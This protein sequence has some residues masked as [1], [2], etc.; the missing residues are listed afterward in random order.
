MTVRLQWVHFSILGVSI[1]GLPVG[2]A[3]VI[4]E[5]GR[6]T[7]DGLSFFFSTIA[8]CQTHSSAGVKGDSTAYHWHSPSPNCPAS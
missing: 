8:Y 3:F 6:L 7:S 4:S 1:N 5:G 2:K